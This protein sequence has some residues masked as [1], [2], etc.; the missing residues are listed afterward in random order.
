MKLGPVVASLATASALAPSRVVDEG[1]HALILHT[2]VY[3]ELCDRVGTFVHHV[4][5]AP[6]PERRDPEALTRTHQRIVRV[7]FPVDGGDVHPLVE[8]LRGRD[9][10]LGVALL[11]DLGEQARAGLLGFGQGGCRSWR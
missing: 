7:G 1:W 3:R 10:P 5:R 8:H 2:M 9:L 6:A 4:P 11:V